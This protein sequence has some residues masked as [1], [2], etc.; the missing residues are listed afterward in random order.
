[1]NGIVRVKNFVITG[2]KGGIKITFVGLCTHI[3][4]KFGRDEVAPISYSLP[5]L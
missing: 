5:K 1:M 3:I 4:V 2:R